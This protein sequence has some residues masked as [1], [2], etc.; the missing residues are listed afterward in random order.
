MYHFT[1]LERVLDLFQKQIRVH[2]LHGVTLNS[3]D[4]SH[5]LLV[6]AELESLFAVRDH[7]KLQSFLGQAH[8]K[9]VT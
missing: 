8:E 2:A 9:L 4:E 1:V 3:P 6:T 7:D 5:L